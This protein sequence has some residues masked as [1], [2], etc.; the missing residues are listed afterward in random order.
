MN[1]GRLTVIAELSTTLLVIAL[2]LGMKHSLDVDHV[3]AVSSI[4]TRAPSVKRTSTLAISWSMGH[5]ITAGIITF[6]LFTF[7]NV[8]IDVLLANFEIIVAF[9]LVTIALLTIAWEFDIIKFGKH[10]HGHLHND[11]TVHQHEETDSHNAVDAKYEHAHIQV[12]SFKGEHKAMSGIGIVHGLAS[13]DEL[14]LFLTL[15][16]GFS[17]YLSILV[18]VFVFTMGVVI[19]MI[20]YS[21]LLNYPIH[22]FG[23]EKVIKT[24]NLG[25]A[26]ISIIYA[27][28]ILLGADALNL[29]PIIPEF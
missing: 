16:L 7:R 9:M 18:G 6:I 26:A 11:G 3:V 2:L 25:I 28:Y 24:V 13:N 4:L 22:R 19:G 12:L 29:L 23:R 21:V 1:G 5:M 15:T 17:D 27:V 20:G 10:S 8:F 14:L